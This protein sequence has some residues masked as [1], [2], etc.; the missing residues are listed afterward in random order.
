MAR[1]SQVSPILLAGRMMQS[2][3]FDHVDD[4]GEPRNAKGGL[5]P[6]RVPPA[7]L[8]NTQPIAD[9]PALLDLDKMPVNARNKRTAKI[10]Q[11]NLW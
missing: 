5:C 10:A 6:P 11:R 4:N 2:P 9:Q 8:N 3:F 7:T 1:H